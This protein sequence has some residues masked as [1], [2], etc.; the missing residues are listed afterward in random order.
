M[1]DA[2]H[3]RG[4]TKKP[5]LADL[6]TRVVSAQDLEGANAVGTISFPFTCLLSIATCLNFWFA[7]ASPTSLPASTA[8]PPSPDRF[9]M[10]VFSPE[11]LPFQQKKERH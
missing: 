6:A 1:A 2:S 10:S 11:L 3:P 4:V 5:L 8:A 7:T 9:R